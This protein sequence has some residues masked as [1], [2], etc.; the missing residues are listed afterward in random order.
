L[1]VNERRPIWLARKLG[2]SHTLVYSWLNRTRNISEKHF[3]MCLQVF[4]VPIEQA[5][6][7]ID[8]E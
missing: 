2:V 1:E 4:D 8:N 5:I 7:E 3:T 6:K